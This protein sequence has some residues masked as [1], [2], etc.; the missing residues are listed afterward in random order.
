MN[1]EL[2]LASDTIDGIL[3]EIIVSNK[4]VREIHINKIPNQVLSLE[5]LISLIKIQKRQKYLHS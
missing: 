1:Q 5:L 4:G 2:F 3:F